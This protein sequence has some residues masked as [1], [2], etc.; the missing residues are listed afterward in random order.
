[1][2]L[3]DVKVANPIAAADARDDAPERSDIVHRVIMLIALAGWANR[4][5]HQ[6][7]DKDMFVQT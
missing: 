5:D 7:A 2:Q 6:R 4:I 3:D 1:M